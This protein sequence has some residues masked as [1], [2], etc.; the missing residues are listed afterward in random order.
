MGSV[1]GSKSCGRRFLGEVLQGLFIVWGLAVLSIAWC[2]AVTRFRDNRH[3]IDDILV[4][5]A[6]PACG[7]TQLPVGATTC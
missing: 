1:W 2:I 7:M 5:L 4:R 3:N 6:Q